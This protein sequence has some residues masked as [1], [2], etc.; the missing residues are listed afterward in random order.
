VSIPE[1]VAPGGLDPGT[2][3]V[4]HDDLPAGERIDATLGVEVPAGCVTPVVWAEGN[5]G[6]FWQLEVSAMYEPAQE[7]A[8]QLVFDMIDALEVSDQIKACM[9]VAVDDFTLSEQDV[10]EY[11]NLDGVASRADQGDE[12]AIQI[13]IDFQ[14]ALSNCN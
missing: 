4:P 6:A 12:R 2:T 7:P 5:A 1:S 9:H 8:E 3:Y 10:Q 14:V 13:M 11:G